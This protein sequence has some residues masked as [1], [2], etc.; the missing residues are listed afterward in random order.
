MIWQKMH[1]FFWN[2]LSSSGDIF[3]IFS[4]ISLICSGVGCPWLMVVRSSAFCASAFFYI[5][6]KWIEG[7]QEAAPRL[8]FA[9]LASLLAGGESA[10]RFPLAAFLAAVVLVDMPVKAFPLE[11]GDAFLFDD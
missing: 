1:C 4:C 3:A 7:I 10:P 5:L 9:P 2:S 8:I 11:I 6:A